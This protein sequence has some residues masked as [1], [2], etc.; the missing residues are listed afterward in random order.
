MQFIKP[1]DWSHI[2]ANSAKPKPRV[3]IP[4]FPGTNCEYDSSKAFTDAG[5]EVEILVVR[6][7]TP[8]DI[9]QTLSAM[10]KAIGKAQIIMLPGGFSGG[11]EPEGSG[12]FIAAALR[13]PA[14]SEQIRML[15]KHRDGLM[16]G[17][18]NGFQAL[19]KLGLLPYGDIVEL[20]TDSPTLTFNRIGRHVSSYVT[21][22]IADNRS[23]WLM[24][25]QP[26]DLH[27]I[28]VSHGEG[29]FAA[30]PDVLKQL[31]E[32][33]QIATQYVDL[34][35]RPTDLTA[36]NPNGSIAAIEGIISPDGRIF[37]KMGHSERR[38]DLLARNIPGEK[39]QKLFAAGVAYFRD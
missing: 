3:F 29:R 35:G 25:T 5:A 15:L 12:K 23:P 26:G 24:Y 20:T 19:V 32:N 4:V 16:L 9:T 7:R 2:R 1:T 8:D 39:D 14:I 36:F 13:N 33:R 18:C 21:T 30:N 38:G 31:I 11:D 28:P 27:Q 37:G 10:E 34:S 17:I 6:N 22:K